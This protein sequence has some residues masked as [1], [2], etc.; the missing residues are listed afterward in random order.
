MRHRRGDRAAAPP[1]AVG[2]ASPISFGE[3]AT[4][5]LAAWLGGGV[6]ATALLIGAGVSGADDAST[7]PGWVVASAVAQ[8]IPFVALVLFLMRRHG[9]T[10]PIADIGLR[11]RP[12][13]LL[14]V[15]AGVLAQVVLVPAVYAPLRRVWPA[16]FDTDAVEQRARDL[17][18]GATGTGAVALVLVVALGAPLVEEVVYRGLLQASL[19]RRLG[20]WSAWVLMALWFAAVHFQPVEVPG[21]FVAGLVFGGAALLTDRLGAGVL[22]HV[23]FNAAGLIVVAQH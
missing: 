21:L 19:A 9:S 14:G 12:A 20:R 5:W 4:G 11:F 23:A 7:A 1:A 17:W 18:G 16:T 2:G 6:F 13:D 8:W 10:R 15:P 3:A 22:A